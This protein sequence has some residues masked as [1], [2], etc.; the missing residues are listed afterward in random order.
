[1]LNERHR[2]RCE[3]DSGKF[4]EIYEAGHAMKLW[5]AWKL[6]NCHGRTTRLFG[7]SDPSRTSQ[8][9]FAAQ[10]SYPWS[11]SRCYWYAR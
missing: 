4:D 11:D 7:V 2:H 10:S 5:I 1:M 6:L 8:S 9:T 3:V